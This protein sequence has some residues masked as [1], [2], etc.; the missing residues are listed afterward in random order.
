MH[1]GLQFCVNQSAGKPQIWPGLQ[2]F[3]WGIPG[4]PQISIKLTIS[5]GGNWILGLVLEAERSTNSI[6]F[7]WDSLSFAT[8]VLCGNSITNFPLF[9]MDSTMHKMGFLIRF[10]LPQYSYC[11]WYGMCIRN[12]LLYTSPGITRPCQ[13][14]LTILDV[15]RKRMKQ[16]VW[17]RVHDDSIVQCPAIHVHID[18]SAVAQAKKPERQWVL[19]GLWYN[20]L[21]SRLETCYDHQTI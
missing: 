12:I 7:C 8:L 11:I 6:C 10:F 2:I 19:C 14:V 15:C 20:D 16:Y 5:K 3:P 4:Y 1:Q 9:G 21:L 18:G 17:L 13:Y